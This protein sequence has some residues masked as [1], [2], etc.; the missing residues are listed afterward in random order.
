MFLFCACLYAW[1][2][3]NASRLRG[4]ALPFPEQ[5]AVLALIGSGDPRA[6]ENLTEELNN[7]LLSVAG[8][9]PL[10]LVGLVGIQAYLGRGFRHS[11]DGAGM[12]RFLLAGSLFLTALMGYLPRGR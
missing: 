10:L 2:L 9:G 6:K 7:P 5:S 12:G 3:W 1:G 4:L 8:L 11:V